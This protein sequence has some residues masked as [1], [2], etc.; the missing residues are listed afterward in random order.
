M[1]SRFKISLGLIAFFPTITLAASYIEGVA[2][3]F[4]SVISILL[5]GF[6]GLV[7]IGFAYGLFIYVKSGAP[8]EKDKGRSIM[9]WGALAVVIMLSIYGIAGLLQNI[10]GATG[11]IV[12]VPTTYKGGGA[13]SGSTYNPANDPIQ[14]ALNQPTP[15]IPDNGLF[16]SN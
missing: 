1:S 2:T 16:P 13:S 14:N 6:V 10:T 8:A 15:I 5:P 11:T 3:S 4:K 7:I 9:T 12:P